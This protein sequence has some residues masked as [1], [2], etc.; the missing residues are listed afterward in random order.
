MAAFQPDLVIQND[1]GDPI[2]LVEVAN[3]SHL[4]RDRATEI[5]RNIMKRGLPKHV[6]YLL[7][8]SQDKGYLWENPDRE[9]EEAPPD[10]EFSMDEVI[11][12]YRTEQMSRRL[13][14][15]VLEFLVFQW[16]MSLANSEQESSEEPE[17]TLS[18][19]GFNKSIKGATVLFGKVG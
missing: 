9:S 8:L 10:Y 17:K 14:T 5:H 13:Y 6:S 11:N 2:A 4:S 3:P 1:E 15:E 12:R 7:L 16:L 18:L 19:S